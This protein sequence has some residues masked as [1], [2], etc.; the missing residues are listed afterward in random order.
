[1]ID[2]KVKEK[3]PS[4]TEDAAQKKTGEQYDLESLKK[5]AP[6]VTRPK[7]SLY[8]NWG[9]QAFANLIIGK[10]AVKRL[11][12]LIPHTLV[13]IIKLCSDNR[14]EIT[15]AYKR[16]LEFNKKPKFFESPQKKYVK[17]YG[18]FVRELEW[19][20]GELR[21]YFT[22]RAYEELIIE[23]TADYIV[24]ILG[25]FIAALNKIML[26][27]KKYSAKIPGPILKIMG[28]FTKIFFERI[29]NITGWLVGDVKLTEFDF[30]EASMV[31]E[32]TDCLLL[33][34]PEMK[35]LPEE[36]CLLGCKGGCE[37]VL[38]GPLKMAFDVK[39]PETTC[40]IRSFLVEES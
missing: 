9:L 16:I 27:S 4:T 40:E 33:R 13:P 21:K 39:L 23:T 32:V 28:A 25:P 1:M 19:S 24:E 20:C 5:F 37:R 34:A 6:T 11:S 17:I 10:A 38:Q 14:R 2:A 29:I 7:G 30:K 8:H 3:D 35:D 31:M 36:A 22:K 12:R 18:A 26:V 15:E